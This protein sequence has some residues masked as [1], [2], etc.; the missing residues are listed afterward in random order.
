MVSER[1][2]SWLTVMEG[3]ELELFDW[4]VFPVLSK[5]SC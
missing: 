3:R 5:V 2:Y 4:G 1:G